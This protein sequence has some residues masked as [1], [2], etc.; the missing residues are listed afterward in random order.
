MILSSSKSTCSPGH[1][2]HCCPHTAVQTRSWTCRSAFKKPPICF[3][4]FKVFSFWKRNALRKQRK[5]LKHN[6]YPQGSTV[7][8]FN[9]GMP[10]TTTVQN[11]WKLDTHIISFGLPLYRWPQKRMERICWIFPYYS[12]LFWMC[13]KT[14]WLWFLNK[15]QKTERCL[16]IYNSKFLWL[17]VAI[18][19]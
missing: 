10:I 11:K 18:S 17:S 7:A 12:I 4:A 8:L 6:R 13:K 2:L 19:R 1:R 3:E 15:F 14:I 5:R 9:S 16:Y